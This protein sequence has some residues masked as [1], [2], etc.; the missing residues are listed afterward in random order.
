MALCK[1]EVVNTLATPAGRFRLNRKSVYLPIKSPRAAVVQLFIVVLKEL[2]A[3]PDRSAL[4]PLPAV[5]LLAIAG[6]KLI[7]RP[8]LRVAK[9]VLAVVVHPFIIRALAR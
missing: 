4:K 8:L 9:L 6:A 7:N 5:L 1:G 3:S 2:L